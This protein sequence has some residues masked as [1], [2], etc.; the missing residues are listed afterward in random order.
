MSTFC[1]KMGVLR[2]YFNT[3]LSRYPVSGFKRRVQT[4]VFILPVFFVLSACDNLD[5]DELIVADETAT[6]EEVAV[7]DAGIPLLID[8]SEGLTGTDYQI[9]RSP[10]R[11]SLEVWQGNIFLYLPDLS[12]TNGQDDFSYRILTTDQVQSRVKTLYAA[13]ERE[14][15]WRP[16]SDRFSIAPTQTLQQD[17]LINDFLPTEYTSQLRIPPNTGN[18]RFD[19]GKIVFEPDPDFL[20]TVAFAYELCQPD[21]GCKLALVEIEVME[22]CLTANTQPVVEQSTLPFDPS[23]YEITNVQMTGDCLLLSVQYAGGCESFEAELRHLGSTESEATFRSDVQLHF[24]EDDPCE[25]LVTEEINFDLRPL[26]IGQRGTV[27]IWLNTW[28]EP[29]LYHY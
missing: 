20:G 4:V 7:V 8:L 27:E 13:Q 1:E 15:V 26:R 23:T 24:F 21:E 6:L 28:A 10:I 25:A 14:G 22:A 11:G 29:L 3:A 19:E 16:R 9:T 17:I 12:F 18:L 2:F 5:S